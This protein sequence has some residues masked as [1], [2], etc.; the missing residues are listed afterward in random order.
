MMIK[1]IGDGFHYTGTLR[2]NLKKKGRGSVDFKVESNSNMICLRWLDT[3]AV[4]L[5]STYAGAT[6]IEKAKRWDKGQ[7]AFIQIDRPFI[8]SEY[9]KC[10]GGIDLFDSC[11]SRYKY[12]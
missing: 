2:A 1:M 12:N 11:V 4:T 5:K 10:I 7:K 9:N 6:P 3:G 8:L